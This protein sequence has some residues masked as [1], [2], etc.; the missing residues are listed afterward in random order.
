ME[1][2]AYKSVPY[3]PQQSVAAYVFLSKG[4]ADQHGFANLR[5]R[6][7][8][9]EQPEKLAPVRAETNRVQNG[10]II[11]LTTLAVIEIFA[12]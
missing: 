12:G 7:R 6:W 4:I 8:C 10:T 11:K 3:H 2:A 9:L 5:T 1:P